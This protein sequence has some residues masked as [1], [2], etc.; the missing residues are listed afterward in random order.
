[1]K[2]IRINS[3]NSRRAFLSTFAL[4]T[5]AFI[6]SIVNIGCTGTQTN[7]P[8]SNF[9]GVK[10]GIISYSWR[11]MPCA[12]EDILNYCIQSGISY[13]ELLGEAAEQYAG[14]PPLPASPG[15]R[16][17]ISDEEA[18]AYREALEEA[19]GKQTEWRLSVSMDKYLELRKMFNEAGV[20]IHIVKFSPAGWTDEEIDY[21][22]VAADGQPGDPDFSF[23]EFLAYSPKNMLNFDVGHYY[24]ATNEHPNKEIERL[25][26]RI[27]SLHLKD[28]TGKF[29]EPANTN[30]AWG[31]GET[32]LADILVLI[33]ENNWPIHCDIELEY[34]VPE[35]SDA[36]KEVSKCVEYCRD[37]LLSDVIE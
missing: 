1:M 21:A 37:I 28:K 26:E 32:P 33:R 25:H 3:G 11:S 27:F 34:E 13:V 31:K 10:I 35:E 19:R 29:S 15:R 18:T 14:I 9:N 12:A 17:E 36:V 6:F 20:D 24:G 30:K 23:D 5:A 4:I 8:D 2:L 7:K 22:F 16:D